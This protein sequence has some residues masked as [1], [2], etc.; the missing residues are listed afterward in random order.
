[1]RLCLSF[2]LLLFIVSA[3]A[4]AQSEVAQG[5]T[6]STVAGDGDKATVGQP[7]GVEFGP[8]G[9]LYVTEVENHRVQ[10]IDLATGKLEVFAGTGT[11]GH[12]GDGG[13]AT[14]A[15]MF[16]PY[17]IRFGPDGETYVVE[18]K[19]HLVRK[20]DRDGIITTIAGTGEAGFGG[21][22]GPATH[23]RFSRP[24]SI[25]LDAKRGLLYIADIG[26][27]RIRRLH[28]ASGIL[29]PYAGTGKRILPVDGESVRG[30][31]MAGPRALFVDAERDTLWLALREGH[32]VWKI[33][34]KTDI[35]KHV[36]GTG[37][38]GYS[39][40][41]GD[42]RKAT[43]KGPKGIA[44]GPAGNVFVVDTENQAIRK[45]TPEGIISSLAGFGP[46]GQGFNGDG[47][48]SKAKMGRPHGICVG[49]DGA[50]Y[51]GDTNNHRVRKIAPSA[52]DQPAGESTLAAKLAA[53]EKQTLVVYGTSLTAGGAWVGQCKRAIEARHPGKLSLVNAAS[54]GKWSTWGL[55]HFQKRVLDKKPDTLL[56]EF[57]INDA[58]LKY[59]TSVALA[60]TNLVTMIERTQTALPD[61][62]IVLMTMN[63]PIGVHLER[64]P[65]VRSY[66]A[67]YR[68]VARARGLRLIDHEPN[69]NAVLKADPDRFNKF[70]PDGI[71]PGPLGCE[72]VITPQLLD[73]LGFGKADP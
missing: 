41:G 54:G 8:D 68:E 27:H 21:D 36:A 61:C 15:A 29:E 3:P 65:D 55:T 6:I 35:I 70:V 44:V 40:D 71:H 1:M 5:A 9:K 2:L 23:A 66:Y 45:I 57:G 63:P 28:L 18:M 19:N 64:R 30:M 31:A 33:A 42:A 37:K 51:V 67:M 72:K 52:T 16:E 11:H 56:I 17:E 34:L 26:N 22:L 32:S 38:K 24:H 58:Y 13:R 4:Q 39:G 59:K 46:K 50:V 10:K 20:I 60:R 69:W 12:N 53:G 48:A 62:E 14:A 43:F 47:P 49:P 73:S 7:F 25:A